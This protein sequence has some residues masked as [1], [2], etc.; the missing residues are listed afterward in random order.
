MVVGHVPTAGQGRGIGHAATAEVAA[1]VA[2]KVLVEM[3]GTV[4]AEAKRK[5]E[6]S[7][8]A[9]RG[10]GIRAVAVRRKNM[11][12]LDLYLQLKATI[13]FSAIVAEK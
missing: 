5:K 1:G 8:L 6:K 4:A 13:E 3:I 9:R 12:G 11:R 10:K 2:K 7:L